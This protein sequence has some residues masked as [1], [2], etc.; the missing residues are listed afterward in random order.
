MKTI[1]ILLS[2]SSLSLA[3]QTY[4]YSS[5]S[6]TGSSVS[7]LDVNLDTG[8]VQ[9][10]ADGAMGMIAQ[11]GDD[12]LGSTLVLYS[13]DKCCHAD[14]IGYM[15]DIDG[16]Q[17]VPEGVGSFRLLDPESPDPEG[18]TEYDCQAT[19]EMD[20]LVEWTPPPY[21]FD[22]NAETPEPSS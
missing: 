19:S 13:G 15:E 2:L 22:P 10:R 21:G 11:F 18:S 8:C 6:C 7:N 16:C 3:A 9:A 14:Q 12:D 4:E 5:S 17:E 20:L 1:S